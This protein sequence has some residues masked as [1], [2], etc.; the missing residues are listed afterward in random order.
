MMWK[1]KTVV[2]SSFA[3][4][5]ATALAAKRLNKMR[6]PVS[7]TDEKA[8]RIRADKAVERNLRRVARADRR[9]ELRLW[10]LGIFHKIPKNEKSTHRRISARNAAEKIDAT[11]DMRTRIKRFMNRRF[12]GRLDFGNGED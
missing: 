5:V 6:Q 8:E 2:A 1:K 12:G 10:I 9:T 3:V 4:L 7:E 11:P